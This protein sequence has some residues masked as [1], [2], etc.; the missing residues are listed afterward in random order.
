MSSPLVQ[1]LIGGGLAI[2]GGLLAAWWQTSRA[3]DIARRVRLAERRED[4]L[5]TLQVTL[6]DVYDRVAGIHRAAVERGQTTAQYVAA[7]AALREASQLWLGISSGAIPDPTIVA[8]YAAFD[9]AVRDRLPG[10]Q[11]GLE[12][13]ANNIHEEGTRFVTDL[14][15]VLGILK[16]FKDA[17]RAEVALMIMPRAH[18]LR[19]IRATGAGPLN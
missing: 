16:Q 1:T 10:D 17:V 11:R 15:Y 7:L 6:T 14:G 19:A 5:L 3:D 9:A 2:L 13:M 8:A 4:A 18:R 12:Y